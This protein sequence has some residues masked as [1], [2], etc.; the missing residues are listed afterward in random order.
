MRDGT[1]T[2]SDGR[3]MTLKDGDMVSMDGKVTKGGM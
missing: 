1:V 3:T 2:N